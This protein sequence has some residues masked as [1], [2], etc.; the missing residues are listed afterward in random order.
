MLIRPQI[1]AENLA[2]VQRRIGDA[3]A[4]AGRNPASVT[5]LAVSKGHP[6]EAVT[7]LARLG[8]DQF[9]ENYLQE[10]LP[11]MDALADL[12]LT[13]HF[14]G[15]VQS[16][17]T[18][19]I[20]ERFAWVHS[21]DRLRIAERLSAQRPHYAPLLRVCLQVKL[22]SEPSKAGVAPADLLPLAL[23][24]ARL[25]RLELRGLMGLP[26]EELDPQRQRHW[27]AELAAYLDSLR[28]G[29]LALDA[30]SMGMSGDLE[31]AIEEGATLVRVGTALF[32]ARAP[33]SAASGNETGIAAGTEPGTVRSG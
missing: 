25:P 26:P 3:A 20:A 12:P 13:W 29:G 15:P 19:A 21:I 24:V 17:K 28:A 11:K 7:E 16:N 30:L 18:A 22:G 23:A 5:L 8:V 33:R 4:A 9:A 1:Y 27:F 32:G 14:I 31:A 6:S 2:R 10:A